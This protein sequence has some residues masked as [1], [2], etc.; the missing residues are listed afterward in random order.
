[1]WSNQ[2]CD[3]QDDVR[4]LKGKLVATRKQL[5]EDREEKMS[6]QTLLKQR[7]QEKRKSQERLEEKNKEVHLVQQKN[8]Q[9]PKIFKCL[10]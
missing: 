1:M 9:V 2:Q 6:L 7:E 5:C 4:V 8:Q 3:L 10:C